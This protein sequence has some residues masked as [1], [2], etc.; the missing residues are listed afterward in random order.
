[1]GVLKVTER[2]KSTGTDHLKIDLGNRRVR[3]TLSVFRFRDKDTKQYVMYAPSLE[4][5]GYGETKSKAE[6][7]FRIMADN[8]FVHLTSLNVTELQ[9]E[10]RKYGW[11]KDIIFKKEYSKAYVDGNGELQNLNAEETSVEKLTLTAA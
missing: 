9:Q 5:S 8:A 3:G 2:G 6:K 1:M 10:L 7:M 4:I 11:K